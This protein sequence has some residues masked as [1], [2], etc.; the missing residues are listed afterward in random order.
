LNPIRPLGV[1]PVPPAKGAVPGHAR[2]AKGGWCF[3]PRRTPDRRQA[4]RMAAGMSA[5][6]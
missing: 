1:K 3:R 6:C 2:G 5:R 4:A